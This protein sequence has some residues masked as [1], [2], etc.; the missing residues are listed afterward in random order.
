MRGISTS[1]LINGS[2]PIR[3]DVGD[4]GGVVGHALHLYSHV[5]GRDDVAQI[6]RRGLL[7]GHGRNVSFS[8]L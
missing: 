4:A 3:S 6:A 1:G 8:I 5:G 7:G 2:S